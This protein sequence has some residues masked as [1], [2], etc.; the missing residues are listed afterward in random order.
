[1][2]IPILHH[3]FWVVR[4]TKHKNSKVLCE[5]TESL[6]RAGSLFAS[7]SILD[8]NV[9][10]LIRKELTKCSAVLMLHKNAVF[11]NSKWQR[12]IWLSVHYWFHIKLLPWQNVAGTNQIHTLHG[13]E[14]TS[15]CAQWMSASYFPTMPNTPQWQFN[16]C[17]IDRV[18]VT[19]LYHLWL[20][21]DRSLH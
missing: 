10:V 11:S 17:S 6:M 14:I 2:D 1:M 7:V 16:D 4:N 9:L 8:G 5:C 19:P 12:S 13:L 15:H 20:Q 21:H 18:T 3:Q